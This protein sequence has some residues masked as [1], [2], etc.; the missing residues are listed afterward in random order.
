M[1]KTD[2]SFEY[3]DVE[4]TIKGSIDSVKNPKSGF[5]KADKI[6]KIILED[7]IM[8]SKCEIKEKCH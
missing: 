3:S 6:K 4:A 1:E 5:I 8:K 7:S 2:L